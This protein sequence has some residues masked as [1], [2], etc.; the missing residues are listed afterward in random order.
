VCRQVSYCYGTNRRSERPVR[1]VATGIAGR[2]KARFEG[3]DRSSQQWKVRR[4][5][6]TVRGAD[7]VV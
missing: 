1:L 4:E 3:P 7:A 6:Q 5:R 2:I